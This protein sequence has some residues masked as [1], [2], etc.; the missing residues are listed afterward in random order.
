MDKTIVKSINEEQFLNN[1]NDVD[2]NTASESTYTQKVPSW[3]GKGQKKLFEKAYSGKSKT[4]ALKA[5]CI[6]CCCGE[7]KE[8]RQCKIHECPLWLYRQ[9]KD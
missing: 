1:N 7:L 6:D 2:T 4:S 8:I 5:K 3:V 9:F